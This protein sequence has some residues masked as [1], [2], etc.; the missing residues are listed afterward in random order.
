MQHQ[1]EQTLL[2]RPHSIHCPKVPAPPHPHQATQPDTT[3]SDALQPNALHPNAMQ[4]DAMQPNAL[5]PSAMQPVALQPY[6]LQPDAKPNTRPA[7]LGVSASLQL[8]EAVLAQCPLLK[9][10]PKPPAQQQHSAA[11]AAR[12]E[13]PKTLLGRDRSEVL[14]LHLEGARLRTAVTPK[15]R[16]PALPAGFSLSQ[17]LHG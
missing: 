15:P 16:A 11:A 13:A 14:P 8:A 9:W 4:L 7:S 2:T 5:Q 3:Q 17:T 1:R 6:A 12:R 10:C